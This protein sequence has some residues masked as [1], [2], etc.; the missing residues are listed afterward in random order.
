MLTSEESSPAGR[1]L[2]LRIVVLQ[3]DPVGRQLA[4]VRGQH[5]RVV[6]R[7]IVPA[8][9]VRHYQHNVGRPVFPFPAAV[10]TVGATVARRRSSALSRRRLL[11]G[12]AEVEEKEEEEED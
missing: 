2:G 1:T 3:D 6:P 5:G 7:Y 4:Q 8:Q 11:F 12:P 10:F 9:I